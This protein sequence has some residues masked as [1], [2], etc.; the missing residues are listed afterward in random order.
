M[1]RK[2]DRAAGT[3]FNRLLSN[4]FIFLVTDSF[5]FLGT[6]VTVETTI[7]KNTRWR[8]LAVIKK[9]TIETLDATETITRG[10]L[11]NNVCW[12]LFLSVCDLYFLTYHSASPRFI[13]HVK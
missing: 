3:N 13:I 7:E 8:K 4:R 9:V 12:L 11:Q 5:C 2:L 1:I 6:N 10:N